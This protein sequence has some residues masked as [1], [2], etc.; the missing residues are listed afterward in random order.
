MCSGPDSPAECTYELNIETNEFVCVCQINGVTGT[1]DG[2]DETNNGPGVDD[3]FF[4]GGGYE[5]PDEPVGCDPSIP[6]S[7]CGGTAYT[8]TLKCT[9]KIDLGVPASCSLEV[10]PSW[11]LEYASWTFSSDGH[12]FRST[13]NTWEGYPTESGLVTANMWI[14]NTGADSVS[15][16]ITVVPTDAC[17]DER[18]LI[19]REYSLIGRPPIEPSCRD[20]T[21]SGGSA[22]F[23]WAE[24]NDNWSGGSG[25]AYY[26]LVNTRLTNG[27]ELTRFYYNNRRIR[28][29][30]GY[31]CPHGN[32]AVGGVPNSWHMAGRAAD[33]KGLDVLI[34]DETA[35]NELWLAAFMAGASEL[36]R[37]NDYTYH[38]LHAMW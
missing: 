29:S 25:H 6:G 17:G 26:G 4:P 21:S 28:L 31:R 22:H 32:R 30:S 18:D 2:G 15:A 20:F 10:S 16:I 19:A 37:Y 27:L 23:S 14:V 3:P 13:T 8:A 38:H 12:S 33:M 9:T 11:V 5:D 7:D 1:A 35:F 34:W 36:N 24:L